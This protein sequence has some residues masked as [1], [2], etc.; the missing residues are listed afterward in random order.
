MVA[1]SPGMA[2]RMMPA[3]TPQTF[4]VR[5]REPREPL[6][7]LTRR[8]MDARYGAEEPGEEAVRDAEGAATAVIADLR[9]RRAAAPGA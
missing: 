4:A 5:V 6:G 2:P 8:F 9:R 3:A 7:A 1:V